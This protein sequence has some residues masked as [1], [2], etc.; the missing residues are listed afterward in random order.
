MTISSG[1]PFFTKDHRV[2]PFSPSLGCRFGALMSPEKNPSEFATTRKSRWREFI[3]EA[4]F[5]KKTEKERNTRA[6]SERSRERLREIEWIPPLFLEEILLSSCCPPHHKHDLKSNSRGQW[7]FS[8]QRE[9]REGTRT[10][11]CIHIP[12]V[13]PC[14]R[15][16]TANEED[17]IRINHTKRLLR[18]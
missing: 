1:F 10:E 8:A 11:K 15:N 12:R 18:L 16:Y 14:K 13:W 6:K 7:C 4:D 17:S 5:R 2:Y 3:Q 9:K